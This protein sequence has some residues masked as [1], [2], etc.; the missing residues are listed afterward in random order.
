M[1]FR[2]TQ[3]RLEPTWP[4]SLLINPLSTRIF[5]VFGHSLFEDRVLHKEAWV[6]KLL[7]THLSVRV[8]K[9]VKFSL[10]DNSSLAL[11][12]LKMALGFYVFLFQLLKVK[13]F[14]KVFYSIVNIIATTRVLIV[15]SLSWVLYI[16]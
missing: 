3:D 5:T 11:K 6:A 16:V 7:G 15:Q 14:L 10:R 9:Q 8:N 13:R 2:I 1:P 12:E 4:R